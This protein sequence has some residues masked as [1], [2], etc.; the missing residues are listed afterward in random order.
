MFCVKCGKE[1]PEGAAFCPACGNEAAAQAAPSVQ[2]EP[3]VQTEPAAQAAPTTITIPPAV[4]ETV[5]KV[6]KKA[7]EGYAMAEKKI[8][9]KNMPLAVIGVVSV[10]ALLLILLLAGGNSSPEGVVEKYMD[11]VLDCNM[12]KF[13]DCFDDDVLD[14]LAD[15]E[16]D[17]SMKELKKELKEAL[18]DAAEDI[19]DFEKLSV[20]GSSKVSSSELESVKV[21]YETI[22]VKVSD[23]AEVRVEFEDADGDT[24][25]EE[26]YVVKIGGKWYMHVIYLYFIG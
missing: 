6:V 25:I 21:M 9:A 24:D 2:A 5:D 19:E 22:D 16:F 4:T 11:A 17:G 7:K 13:M 14:E 20:I 15:K 23:A 10:L 12:S 18:Q 26:Y 8:G 1:I 3:A